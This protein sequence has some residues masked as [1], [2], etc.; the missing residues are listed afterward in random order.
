MTISRYIAAAALFAAATLGGTA[1]VWGDMP[2]DEAWKAMPAYEHGQDM[3]PLLAI[4]RAVIEAMATPETRAACA[5]RLAKLLDD[6]AATLAA[7]QHASMQLR[8]IGT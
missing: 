4:D 5:A 8:Q 6:S 7:K 2:I 3:A 1:G